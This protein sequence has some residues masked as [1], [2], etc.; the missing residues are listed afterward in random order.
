MSHYYFN[1]FYKVYSFSVEGLF[2]IGPTPSSLYAF[3][4]SSYA[5]KNLFNAKLINNRGHRLFNPIIRHAS[6]WRDKGSYIYGNITIS[7]I[8]A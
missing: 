4:E 5:L 6:F 8:I 1:F 3:R 2:S 7:D